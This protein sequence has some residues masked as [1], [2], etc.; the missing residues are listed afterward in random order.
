MEKG[1][2][3]TRV[4]LRCV[5]V[6]SMC[7]INVLELQTECDRI[8]W[9]GLH[10]LRKSH[11]D[12][13]GKNMS[14]RIQHVLPAAVLG[15]L[16]PHLGWPWAPPWGRVNSNHTTQQL[17]GLQRKAHV[18]RHSTCASPCS[19]GKVDST[20]GP[21]V[22]NGD[23]HQEP[24][25]W[26]WE[27]TGFYFVFWFVGCCVFIGCCHALSQGVGGLIHELT[28]GASMFHHAWHVH[29]HAHAHAYDHAHVW[30]THACSCTCTLSCLHSF[31]YP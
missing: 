27:V 29:M 20:F 10:M 30:F 11:W 28:R 6:A 3:Y 31:F 26:N 23:H 5:L 22:D 2:V 21:R 13:S 8:I 19:L 16:I 18:A 15:R 9:E 7:A 1:V 17:L 24:W 25:I 14:P 12:C 4:L